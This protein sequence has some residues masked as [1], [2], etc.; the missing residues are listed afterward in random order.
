MSNLPE[1]HPE[2]VYIVLQGAG[3]ISEGRPIRGNFYCYKLERRHA[4][5]L[6]Q[7]F[8]TAGNLSSTVAAYLAKHEIKWSH[9]VDRDGYEITSESHR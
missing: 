4:K 1:T 9:Q 7:L 5:V 8:E 2:Y 3:I 6:E